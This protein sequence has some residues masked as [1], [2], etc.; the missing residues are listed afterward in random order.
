M[1]VQSKTRAHDQDPAAE[2]GMAS[3]GNRVGAC[4]RDADVDAPSRMAVIQPW[5]TATTR[6]LLMMFEQ[7][8]TAPALQDETR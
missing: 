5:Q 4:C 1:N 6:E 8:K 7:L 2:T 3:G